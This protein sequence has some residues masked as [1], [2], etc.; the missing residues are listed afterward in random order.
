MAQAQFTY[1][2]D[3]PSASYTLAQELLEISGLGLS[4][5]M[6]ELYAINDEQGIVFTLDLQGKIL[7]Q[8]GFAADSD[9]EG[10][11]RVEDILYILKSNGNLY[12]LDLKSGRSLPLIKSPLS[13]VND[14]E[15]LGYDPV[16]HELLVA[17]KASS[18]LGKP[19]SDKKTKAVYAY[20]L[21]D[22]QWREDPVLS[23]MDRELEDCYASM[24]LEH[25]R[26]SAREK[27]EARVTDFAPSAIAYNPADQLYY[28]LSTVG[29]LLVSCTRTGEIRQ[30]YFLDKNI[31][32]QPEG[33]C[34][35]QNGVMY[36]SNEGKGLSPRL[37]VILPN[38]S[39]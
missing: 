17:C 33:I 32:I 12:R 38:S 3:Q 6:S 16:H 27:L 14:T 2:V 10:I 18:K 29:K 30:V 11:E 23:I 22:Q 8:I 35:D 1:Q 25:L 4:S 24:D 37:H 36:I 26:K 31:H 5:D 21:I 39:D 20:S 9:Y 34:F 28:I 19:A 7:K 15:G 13:S